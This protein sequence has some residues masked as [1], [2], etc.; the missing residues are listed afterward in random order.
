MLIKSSKCIC[1]SVFVLFICT[2]VIWCLDIRELEQV[3]FMELIGHHCSSDQTTDQGNSLEYSSKN[4]FVYTCI[5]NKSM[6][7]GCFL[8][9]FRNR[10]TPHFA[11]FE[12]PKLPVSCQRSLLFPPPSLHQW[13]ALPATKS[14][15]CLKR[16]FPVWRKNIFHFKGQLL[17]C[18]FENILF[19]ASRHVCYSISWNPLEP[20]TFCANNV[21]TSWGYNVQPSSTE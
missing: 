21:K 20:Q 12:F 5:C 2:S 3:W 1:I 19:L 10:A 7:L 18:S 4:V 11:Q 16:I 8:C 14:C 13:L 6:G 9:M 17:Q 15:W